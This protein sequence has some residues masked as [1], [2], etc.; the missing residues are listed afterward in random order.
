MKLIFVPLTFR[1]GD[2]D[3]IQLTQIPE[4]QTAG[5]Y[6]IGE[7]DKGSVLISGFPFMLIFYETWKQH[8]I[9]KLC[10]I[11]VKTSFSI[12]HHHLCMSQCSTLAINYC[13]ILPSEPVAKIFSHQNLYH[14]LLW[15]PHFM[16]FLWKLWCISI[17]YAPEWFCVKPSNCILLQN[18]VVMRS[19]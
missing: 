6:R 17:V 15:S 4:S 9:Q 10:F 16:A 1:P 8:Q 12:T 5:V 13:R 3:T 19:R 14:V 7:W 2:L 18:L 11:S